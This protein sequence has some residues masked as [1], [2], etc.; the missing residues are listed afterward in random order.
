MYVCM[1][2]CLVV[3]STPTPFY[4]G[5]G[6]STR[7]NK[8]CSWIPSTMKQVLFLNIKYDE[9]SHPDYQVQVQSRVSQVPDVIK[10]DGTELKA[11]ELSRRTA[12]SSWRQWA[13]FSSVPT[14]GGGGAG[15]ADCPPWRVTSKKKKRRKKVIITMYK[16]W[17]NVSTSDWQASKEA[18]KN[19]KESPTQQNTKLTGGG[20]E[21]SVLHI[22]R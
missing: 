17:T 22:V 16:R 18:T 6:T 9:T 12:Q 19:G 21:L 5:D 14:G 2:F 3:D 13:I 7:W 10:R 4:S 20:G 1:C 8:Y 11:T 15:G